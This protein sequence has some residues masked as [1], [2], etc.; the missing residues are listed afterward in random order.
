MNK[1]YNK[2]QI[3]AVSKQLL[4][5]GGQ[6]VSGIKVRK[7]A[8]E[9]YRLYPIHFELQRGFT[10]PSAHGIYVYFT[11]MVSYIFSHVLGYFAY[12]TSGGSPFIKHLCDVL[13]AQH[14]EEDLLTMLTHVNW[15]VATEYET[16]MKE[17]A[18]NKRRIV[19]SLEHMLLTEVYLNN[20]LT[21]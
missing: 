3:K 4:Y 5:R 15:K 10:W 16:R 13:D 17:A 12:H 18:F 14:E 9:R 19:P 1:W 7:S 8:H 2:S 6:L 20:K 21:Q 11:G